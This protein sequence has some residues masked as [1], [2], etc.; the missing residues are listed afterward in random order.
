MKDKF[1]GWHMA[2]ILVL[3][4]GV[5]VGVNFYMAYEAR[6]SFNGVVVENSYVAS[7]KYN[8]WLEQE[9]EQEA[10]G[11]QAEL[12]RDKAGLVLVTTQGVPATAEVTAIARRPLG[13]DEEEILQFAG[14]GDGRYISTSPLADG[15]WTI[16]V[17]IRAGNSSWIEEKKI[18]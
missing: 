18:A 6:A 8:G 2:A 1:T 16:R 10:L 5:V 9:K 3:G 17:I 15:R 11:W 13:D 14:N 12:E 4:F 7:Q